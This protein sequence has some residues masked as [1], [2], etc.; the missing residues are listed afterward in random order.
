M[1]DRIGTAL[2][3]VLLDLDGD[4]VTALTFDKNAPAGEPQTEPG[5]RVARYFAGELDA[6]EG[7]RLAPQ[8]TPF[9]QSVWAELLKIPCGETRSYGDLA[10]ALKSSARAV[11]GANGANPIAV[12]IPC[13]RVIAADGTLGGYSGGLDKKR[14][15]LAHEQRKLPLF[16]HG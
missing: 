15:L 10:R 3:T 12:I 9:Q 14:F 11:G 13:H 2:G 5:R 4:A 7:L 8:G 1:I 16:A 6:F